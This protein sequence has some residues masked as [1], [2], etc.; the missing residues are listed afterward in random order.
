MVVDLH[1]SSKMTEV[2]VRDVELRGECL[3]LTVTETTRTFCKEILKI[4]KDGAAS[5]LDF[6]SF[7]DSRGERKSGSRWICYKTSYWSTATKSGLL[8]LV[9]C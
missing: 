8:S 7:S 2:R 9:V 5:S 3:L 1:F 6:F 4:Q